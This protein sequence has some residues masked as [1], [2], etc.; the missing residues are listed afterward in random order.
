MKTYWNGEEC[1]AVRAIAT[2]ED[3]PEF[4]AYWAQDFVGDRRKIVWVR[5]GDQE[6]FLDNEDGQG[7]KKVTEGKGSP[8]V[9]HKELKVSNLEIQ[10]DTNEEN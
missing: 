3:A 6:F 2:V 1:Q 4:L 5:Y 7:W 10:T 9:G 8:N